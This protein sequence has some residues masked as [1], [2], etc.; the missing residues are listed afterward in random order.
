MAIALN[1]SSYKRQ[2]RGKVNLVFEWSDEY[3]NY[4]LSDKKNLKYPTHVSKK[5]AK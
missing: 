3:Q 2:N 5:I 1:N 4:S